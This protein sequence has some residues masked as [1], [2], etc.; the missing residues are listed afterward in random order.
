VG[1]WVGLEGIP[2]NVMNVWSCTSTPPYDLVELTTVVYLYPTNRFNAALKTL[3]QSKIR[4]SRK[5]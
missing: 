2:T 1:T 3:R 5:G 4:E